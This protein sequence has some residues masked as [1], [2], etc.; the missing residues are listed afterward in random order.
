MTAM[1]PQLRKAEGKGKR[2]LAGAF[3]AQKCSINFSPTEHNIT[4]LNCVMSIKQIPVSIS[5]VSPTAKE[6]NNIHYY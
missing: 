3:K 4:P 5:T 2:V 6:N 1:C